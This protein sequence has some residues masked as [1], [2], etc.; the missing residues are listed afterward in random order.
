MAVQMTM[1]DDHTEGDLIQVSPGKFVSPNGKPPEQI[2]AEVFH[3]GD[4]TLGI[5]PLPNGRYIRLSRRTVKL[6]G[7]SRPT[8]IQ[9]LGIAGFVEVARPSPGVYLLNLDSWLSHLQRTQ[10]DPDFWD[11]GGENWNTYMFKNGFRAE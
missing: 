8:T 2:L 5:R 6:L 1:F 11:E 7:I 4:G 10:D 9:R 3:N